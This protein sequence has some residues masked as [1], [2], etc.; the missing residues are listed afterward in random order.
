[1]ALQIQLKLLFN[2]YQGQEM[3]LLRLSRLCWPRRSRGL[4]QALF[5]PCATIYTVFAHL[6]Y[7]ATSGDANILASSKS[8]RL[9]TPN[10]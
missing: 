6:K 9:E 7:F 2:S 10:R 4:K 1:M 5:G 3:H 8:G